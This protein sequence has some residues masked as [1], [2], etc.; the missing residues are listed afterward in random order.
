METHQKRLIGWINFSIFFFII[1]SFTALGI[2]I[3]MTIETSKT[4]DRL[5][6]ELKYIQK[7]L[8]NDNICIQLDSNKNIITMQCNVINTINPY[9][10]VSV[11]PNGGSR[12]TLI[13]NNNENIKMNFQKGINI[14]GMQFE[15]EI[16][17]NII[18]VGTP[19]NTIKITNDITVNS[20]GGFI[21]GDI[22]TISNSFLVT[23]YNNDV[24]IYN[25]QSMRSYN[26]FYVGSFDSTSSK[27]TRCNTNLGL[28]GP[29]MYLLKKSD[30]NVCFCHCISLGTSTRSEY[31]SENLIVDAISSNV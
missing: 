13:N 22:G 23:D 24:N 16:V 27:S 9:D 10:E 25:P 5:D 26:N 14:P 17:N 8:Y 21:F 2:G 18:Q 3:Y 4:D 28:L 30:G 7:V 15:K 29:S 6:N 19:I 1:V 20:D 31:C 11:N 12:E